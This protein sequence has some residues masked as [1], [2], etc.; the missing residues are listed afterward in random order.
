MPL[1]CPDTAPPAGLGGG[2][3]PNSKKELVST[4]CFIV[5]LLIFI[6]AY[7]TFKGTQHESTT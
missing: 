2:E 6:G 5:L 3:H 7:Y 1:W 4:F